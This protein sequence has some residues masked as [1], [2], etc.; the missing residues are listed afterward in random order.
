MKIS[1][2]EA[3]LDYANHTLLKTNILSPSIMGPFSYF[4]GM[5]CNHGVISLSHDAVGFVKINGEDKNITKLS[6]YIEK[7]WGESFPESWLWLQCNG[8]S[9]R[10]GEYSCMCSYASIPYSFLKF[11]GLIAVIMYNGVQH[12]FATYNFSKV[13]K[14]AR[15]KRCVE[16]TIKKFNLELFIKAE[17]SEA[18]VLKAPVAAG[19]AR[20]I[21]ESLDADISVV[22]KKKGK[23][24]FEQTHSMGG[25]EISEID[26]II[27]KKARH[28]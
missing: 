15:N 6:G 22:L 5:Q 25:L 13:T 28:I 20:D 7:D 9:N 21:R 27:N 4:P 24:I 23:I 8:K 14:L 10:Y 12:R 2:I 26:S 17:S 16:I 3:N 18:S 11:K 1:V 19:M